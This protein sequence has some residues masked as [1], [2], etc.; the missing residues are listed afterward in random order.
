MITALRKLWQHRDPEVSLGYAVRCDLINTKGWEYNWMRESC[1]SCARPQVYSLAPPKPK[2]TKGGYVGKEQFSTEMGKVRG[3]MQK[4]E[5]CRRNSESILEL[6]LTNSL[7]L[8]YLCLT[9]IVMEA[10]RVA[11]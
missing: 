7:A 6:P 2:Q 4:R 1:L 11:S 10:E 3:F 8:S 5:E 9:A